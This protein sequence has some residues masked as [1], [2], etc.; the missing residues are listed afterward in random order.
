MSVETVGTYVSEDGRAQ[1][2]RPRRDGDLV[3]RVGHRVQSPLDPG[4]AQDRDQDGRRQGQRQ[5]CQDKAPQDPDHGFSLVLSGV[6]G[7][8]A[9]PLPGLRPARR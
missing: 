6:G 1:R 9:P 8:P 5:E 3:P 2:L 7:S 4:G